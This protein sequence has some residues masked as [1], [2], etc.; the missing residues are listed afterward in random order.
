MHTKRFPLLVLT[1][2]MLVGASST[3]QAQETHEWTLVSPL[4]PAISYMALYQELANNISERSDGRLKINF[5]SYGQHPFSGAEIL[6]AVRDGVVQMGNTADVYVSSMEP[7]IAFLGLPF[8]FDNL[9]QAKAAYAELEDPYYRQIF[10]DK[11]NAELTTGFVIS[12]S[13]IHANRP[14]NSIEAMQGQKIRVFGH[15]SGEMIRLLGGEPSTVAFGELYTSLQRGTIDGALTG[16]DGA[17]AARVYEVV[18]NNTWWNWSY[19]VEFT[20]VNQDAMEA[21]PEDLQEIVREEASLINE[22]I[23]TD[24]DIGTMR[25]L[26]DSIEQYGITVSGLDVDTL[27]EFRTRTQP[28]RDE[29]LEETG[30]LGQQAFSI[31]EQGLQ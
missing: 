20:F 12:G 8:L 22:R 1:A 25:I 13:A 19:P 16:M 11:Y 30:E 31:Y 7:S 6:S 10:A 4:T 24:R 9:E 3:S 26:I 5:L 15:E 14:L 27:E 21:L 17:R 28:I 23:Q 18:D 29:W 2:A